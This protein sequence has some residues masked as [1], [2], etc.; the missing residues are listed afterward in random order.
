M[1]SQKQIAKARKMLQDARKSEKKMKNLAVDAK[2]YANK[3]FMDQFTGKKK[4]FEEGMLSRTEAIERKEKEVSELFAEAHAFYAKARNELDAREKELARWQSN[5]EADAKIAAEEHI[6]RIRKDNAT[7]LE[8]I[9]NARSIESHIQGEVA[10]FRNKL[11]RF[12]TWR[13]HCLQG[14]A[15]LEDGALNEDKK[16]LRRR[17]YE[18][19]QDNFSLKQEVARQLSQAKALAKELRRM[20]SAS[21]SEEMQF[22]NAIKRHTDSMRDGFG[23]ETVPHEAVE[24]YKANAMEEER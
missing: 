21:I 22:K 13:K 14:I 20:Q 5:I 10:A 1:T 9:A 11:V 24:A 18:K 15:G 8:S 4:D 7:L 2:E 23:G 3:V 19:T 12:N 6:Q 17:L 16:A